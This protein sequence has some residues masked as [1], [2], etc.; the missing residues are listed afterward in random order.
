MDT[1]APHSAGE[2]HR[3]D[4]PVA[5]CEVEVTL[6][7]LKALRRYL[8]RNGGRRIFWASAVS[9]WGA[10]TTFVA[11]LVVDQFVVGIL[12]LVT[13]GGACCSQRWGSGVSGILSRGVVRYRVDSSGVRVETGT[14][15]LTEDWAG[16]AGIV[17]TS[18][19]FFVM[20]SPTTAW[21][22]PKRRFTSEDALAAMSALATAHHLEH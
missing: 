8:R 5:E 18:D 12:A 17:E 7:D 19:H 3:A 22:L 21:L 13:A 10:M 16:L 15:V 11:A 14:A 4:E 9:F 1:P 20:S 2:Q 6:D